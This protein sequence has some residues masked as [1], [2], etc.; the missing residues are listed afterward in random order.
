MHIIICRML[1][2]AQMMYN[3]WLDKPRFDDAERIYQEHLQMLR[4]G[5]CSTGGV[6]VSSHQTTVSILNISI[7]HFRGIIFCLFLFFLSVGAML[8]LSGVWWVVDEERMRPGHWFGL[9]L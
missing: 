4:A 8:L 7:F 1:Q 5:G 3:V 6:C 2:M 9:V